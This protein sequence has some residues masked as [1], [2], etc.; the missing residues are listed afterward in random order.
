MAG[1][2]IAPY[3]AFLLEDD[4]PAE[5]LIAHRSLIQIGG[6]DSFDDH[7]GM[8]AEERKTLREKIVLHWQ[9]QVQTKD[10]PA[11]LIS[12]TGGLDMEKVLTML[13]QR[14][15]TMIKLSE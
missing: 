7:R 15:Q 2:W 11:L 12:K 5:R 13:K 14:D 9:K 10:Q 1:H 6:F 3:L 4:Y 8:T